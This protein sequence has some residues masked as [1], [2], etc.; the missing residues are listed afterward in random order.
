MNRTE[1][2]TLVANILT[3]CILS[4][5]SLVPSAARADVPTEVE[6]AEQVA[7]A[8]K[9]SKTLK[10]TLTANVKDRKQ[11]CLH[12]APSEDCIMA[13]ERVKN[14]FTKYLQAL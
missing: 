5:G 3:G 6:F 7:K 8:L 1:N 12:D 13:T 10:A 9:P 2:R 4:L 14:T 11:L